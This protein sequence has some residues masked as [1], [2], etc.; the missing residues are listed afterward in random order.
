M[1]IKVIDG[2][3]TI[4]IDSEQ[5]DDWMKSLPGYQ[6]E[7]AIHEALAVKYAAEGKKKV[8]VVKKT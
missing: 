6:D 8:R 4:V 3:P 2:K 1:S 7:V 5:N